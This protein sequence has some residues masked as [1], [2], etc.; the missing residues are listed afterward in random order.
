VAGVLSRLVPPRRDPRRPRH[1]HHHRTSDLLNPRQ[2][3]ELV[4]AGRD[5]ADLA[6]L[7]DLPIGGTRVL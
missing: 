4:R 6:D 3:Y 7:W 1:F 5:L 2:A